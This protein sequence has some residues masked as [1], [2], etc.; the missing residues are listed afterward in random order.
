MTTP[1]TAATPAT[2]PAKLPA[3]P[4][5]KRAKA[6]AAAALAEDPTTSEGVAQRIRT[7]SIDLTPSVNRIMNAG[8]HE[9]AAFKAITLFRDS[10]GV[11]GDPNRYPDNAIEAGRKV[12]EAAAA[13]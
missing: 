8:L 12:K 6:A 1:A 3:K 2:Q 5:T 13:K 9:A 7:E 4:T 11:P 10:L